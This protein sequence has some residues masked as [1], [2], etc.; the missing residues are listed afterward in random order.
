[1]SL[2]YAQDQGTLR[3]LDGTE[4]GKAGLATEE[5][6]EEAAAR[7]RRSAFTISSAACD[8]LRRP[9]PPPFTTATLQQEA[10]RLFGLG[11][12]ETM[13]I[14]RRLYE[15][16]DLGGERSG[17]VTYVRTDTIAMAKTALARARATI[18]ERHGDDYLSAQA[19]R[20]RDFIVPLL[21]APDE[22]RTRG[23]DERRMSEG[24]TRRTVCSRT[25]VCSAD[26]RA[27]GGVDP[28]SFHDPGGGDDN[29]DRSARQS[30][31]PESRS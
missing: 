2:R 4:A 24:A 17:L 21:L 14:A 20:L 23:R 30:D 7:I 29:S 11:V 12:G 25:P 22:S 26:G 5:A 27:S 9:P 28:G 8:I 16:V 15:G 3:R 6:A 31:E 18:R 1:M 10:W 13:E 19:R